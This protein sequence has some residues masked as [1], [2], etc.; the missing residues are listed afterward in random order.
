MQMFL[1]ILVFVILV[2]YLLW[3][4]VQGVQKKQRSKETLIK[5]ALISAI[6]VLMFCIEQLALI[7]S[8]LLSRLLVVASLAGFALAITAMFKFPRYIVVASATSLLLIYF[9]INSVLVP[10]S[11]IIRD[12]NAEVII[13]TPTN[14]GMKLPEKD[15]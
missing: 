15:L 10:S 2:G 12:P 6:L 14:S 9:T 1:S 3:Q 4:I 11:A 7:D 5:M 8:V 13:I